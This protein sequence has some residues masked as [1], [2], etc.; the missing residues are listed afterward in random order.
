M[1]INLKKVGAFLLKWVIYPVIGAIV[2]IVIISRVT[3]WWRGPA[4][5]KIYVVSNFDEPLASQI[6]QE[7]ISDIGKDLKIDG[8][9]V[10]PEILSCRR[11]AEAKEVSERLAKSR[12]VLMVIG[13]FYSSQTEIALPNY[14]RVYPPIPVILTTE[15]NPK[16]MPEEL[17]DEYCPVFRL[18]PTDDQQAKTAADFAIN[19][20]GSSTFWV[21]EDTD[22]PVYSQ[23]L[24]GEFIDVVHKQGKQVVARFN[25]L[26]IPPIETGE[27]LKTDC[28]FFAGKSSNALILIRQI[29]A[30]WNEAQLPTIIL[31]DWAVGSDLIQQG[32]RDVEGIYLTHQLS[33]DLY[34][35]FGY[36]L[37][38]ADAAGIVNEL[39]SDANEKFSK[40]ARGRGAIGFWLKRLFNIKRVNDARFVLNGLMQEAMTGRVFK[41][42]KTQEEYRFH[43]NAIREGSVFRIWTIRDGKFVQAD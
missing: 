28:V 4:S 2:G 15:T 1:T 36:A 43:R 33:A 16:L 10:E 38:G 3:A 34:N 9:K 12:D 35:N 22:N 21:V 30:L 7:F 17:R 23:Y 39:I 27:L 18:S 20:K 31:S 24:S 26:T 5:Y 41:S 42:A 13:H 25:N 40:R 32:G 11:P 6:K 14:L 29:R 8:V 19:K 37:Y